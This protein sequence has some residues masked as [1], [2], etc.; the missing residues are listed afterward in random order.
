[1]GFIAKAK[2]CYEY[3]LLSDNN[4]H[5]VKKQWNYMCK[6]DYDQAN[7]LIKRLYPLDKLPIVHL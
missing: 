1:M 4:R 6:V 3:D 5:C 7:N 2:S